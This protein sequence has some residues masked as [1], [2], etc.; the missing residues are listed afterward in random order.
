MNYYWVFQ[1]K[2]YKEEFEGSFLWA[3]KSKDR[4]IKHWE[5]MLKL[6]IGDL[7]IH[8]YFGKIVAIGEVTKK[9]FECNQPDNLKHN[10]RWNNDG[11][12]ALC[13]YTLL[14]IPLSTKI[15]NK[16]VY[17]LQPDKNGPINKLGRGN[18][19][20]LFDLNLE[21]FNYIK[22]ELKKLGNSL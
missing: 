21:T 10:N 5:T 15:I 19:G 2:T 13:K 1:N 14:N 3:P 22:E 17:E 20:Y 16:K 9:S 4:K 8:S 11:Y 6:N 18:T 12:K 7:I